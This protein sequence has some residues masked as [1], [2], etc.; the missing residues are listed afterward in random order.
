MVFDFFALMGA[1][2]FDFVGRGAGIDPGAT[3]TEGEGNEHGQQ[4]GDFFFHAG[5]VPQV[6]RLGQ[7]R[8]I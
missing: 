6:A 5:S 8:Y 7:A 1:G 3:G 2:R 4:G